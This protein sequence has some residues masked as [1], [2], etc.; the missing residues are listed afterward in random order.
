MAPNPERDFGQARE[1]INRGESRAAV[2]SLDRARKGYLKRSD[3][4][5]LEHVRDLLELVEPGDDPTRIARANLDYAVKQNLRQI[6]RVEALRTGARWIDPYPNLVSSQE[7]TGIHFSR[8]IKLAIAAGG[9]LGIAAIGGCVAF[10]SSLSLG[11]LQ[12]RF[13][14]DTARP[15]TI[16]W[17]ES[18]RCD[19]DFD[20]VEQRQIAAG[21]SAVISFP[22]DDVVDLVVVFDEHGRRAGCLPIQVDAPYHRLHGRKLVVSVRISRRTACPGT[23]LVE[24]ALPRTRSPRSSRRGAA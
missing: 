14:N 1:E 9:V 22:H 16:K 15:V 12:V 4:Y 6:T 21:S 18:D 13:R 5:G 24:P 10:V 23:T 8:W 7:H 19:R 3:R 17:C 11:D 20:P 2:R